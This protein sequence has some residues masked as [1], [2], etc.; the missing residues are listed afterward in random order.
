V[1]NVRTT[2]L[3]LCFLCCT[4]ALLA[5]PAG[6]AP[7]PLARAAPVD[8]VLAQV[9]DGK[10]RPAIARPF[11]KEL[12]LV[13]Q[14]YRA[15][16]TKE[17]TAAWEKV[18]RRMLNKGNKGQAGPVIAY[19][20]Y[21]A[22]VAPKPKLA[23]IVDRYRFYDQLRQAISLH[24]TRLIAARRGLRK[25]QKVRIR[26]TTFNLRYR[27]GIATVQSEGSAEA[28]KAGI[29][30]RA[31]E[32]EEIADQAVEEAKQAADQAKEQFKLAMRILQEH[33]ERMTQVTQKITS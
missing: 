24:R 28:D 22:H 6:A 2:F 15:G 5:A 11:A 13:A 16:K 19:V 12:A 32:M 9:A 25:G 31:R 23:Q 3:E 1:T 18:A 29:E 27:P 4:T 7:I 33:M 21:L 17:G 8:P 10:V 20:A 30:R 26:A 14:L